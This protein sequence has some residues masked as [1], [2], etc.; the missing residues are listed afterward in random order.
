MEL[1]DLGRWLVGAGLVIAAVGAVF[2]AAGA[3]GLGRLPG[4]FAFGGDRVRVYVP[5]A[6]CILIS[7][8]A[9]VVLNLFFRR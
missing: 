3:V 4:D 1:S 6:S 7:I 8:L 2:L 5:L 9:T